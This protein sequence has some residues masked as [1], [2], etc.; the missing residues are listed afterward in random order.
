MNILLVA[1][2]F[3]PTS[4]GGVE[5]YTYD[6]ANGLSKR[7]HHVTVFCREPSA[8]TKD[9]E[10]IQD[11]NSAYPVFRVVNDYK[12]VEVFSKLY[13]DSKIDNIF[14]SLINKIHPD[15]V[16]FNHFIALSS[17]LPSISQKYHIPSVITL[18][19]YWPICHRINLI[20][21]YKKPCGGPQQGADCFSCVFLAG[22]RRSGVRNLIFFYLKQLVPY[23]IR[24]R[25]RQ[26]I[27]RPGYDTLLFKA[28][29]NDFT[30]RHESF[31]NA[32]GSG[33]YLTSPSF[34]VREVYF[35]NGYKDLDIH[36][37]PLG[38]EKLSKNSAKTSQG[39]IRFAFIGT[40]LTVKAVDLLIRAF[41]R[42]QNQNIVLSIY[43]REDVEPHYAKYVHDLAKKDPRIHFLGPFSREIKQNIYDQIDVLVIPSITPETF[44]FVCRE[45]LE[46][47]VPVVASSIGAVPEIVQHGKNGFIFPVGNTAELSKV[48]MEISQ[49]PELLKN[50]NCPGDVE[51]LSVEE[52]VLRMETVYRNLL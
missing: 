50:L 46:S 23:S 1:N 35:C 13:E 38:V 24:A 4:Y 6:L 52:H 42:V 47:G 15:L 51:I 48:I 26:K 33:N 11:Q 20:N 18:H 49:N 12:K 39:K 2:G 5:A 34:Y 29:K 37:L 41:S 45:A 27:R 25:L 16:H 3:P 30:I 8:S 44:S 31:R 22:E 19:D 9:Y 21:A 14:D 40:L 43:G 7:G 36:V 28:S 10:L 32:L 17:N